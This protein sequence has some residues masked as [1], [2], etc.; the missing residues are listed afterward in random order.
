M[1]RHRRSNSRA[2]RELE[3]MKMMRRGTHRLIG[4]TRDQRGRKTESAG[5]SLCL[6]MLELHAIKRNIGVSRCSWMDFIWGIDRIVENIHGFFVP[7]QF[8]TSYAAAEE[9]KKR[10]KEFFETKFGALPIIVVLSPGESG[11]D[12]IDS[13]AERINNWPGQFKFKP[14]HL[15]YNEF[16]DLSRHREL[17]RSAQLR[18]DA[19]FEWLRNKEKK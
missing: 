18:I 15:R 9:F 6:K 1:G 11:E 8:K 16:F 17:G 3:R 10:K 4:K 19:F 13:L 7:I 14:G 5:N 12:Q 2:K